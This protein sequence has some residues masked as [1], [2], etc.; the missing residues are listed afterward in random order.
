MERAW[1]DPWHSHMLSFLVYLTIDVLNNSSAS[2][3][4][5]AIMPQ[6]PQ[7]GAAHANER[8]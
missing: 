1:K 6:S 2:S 5:N 4:F 3:S 8:V 7:T